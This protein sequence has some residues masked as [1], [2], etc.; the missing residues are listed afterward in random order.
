[1]TIDDQLLPTGKLP[2]QLLQRLLDRYVQIDPRVLIGPEVGSDAAA[3]R[4]DAGIL[5]VKS[6]PITFPTPD[7]ASYL[8]NVNANDVACMGGT[9]RW[10]LVTALLPSGD[11][12][13]S[14]VEGIFHQLSRACDGLGIVLVGG[15]TEITETVRSPVLVGTLL[16]EASDATLL[17]LRES[18]SG[19]DLLLC[20][21]I[22]IE[23]TAILAS[24][25]PRSALESVSQTLIARA[26]QLTDDPGISIVPAA[27]ALRASGATIRGMHDPTEG[28]IA[29]ALGEVAQISRCDIQLSIDIP[30]RED[31]CAICAALG[32]N[33]LG[34]IASGALL[35]VVRRGDAA[36]AL[37][38][39]RSVG[40]DAT[41]LGTLRT[42][43]GEP[44]VLMPDGQPLR[45]FEVDEIARYF[46][47]LN[48][49]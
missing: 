22:A 40:I 21:T 34:L 4:L 13:A 5:I 19:D 49:K 35:A 31:T 44:A 45:T 46:S 42:S 47:S 10:M 25:A 16:G 30:V 17:D 11:T 43:E 36:Q 2:G 38:H 48:S 32:L 18:R 15:H 26:R 37:Y 8:V 23:G 33:P 24:E 1:V 14:S 6:D 3:I 41:H 28:G 29:T 20:N 12:T 7:I 9:P 39:L 27:R